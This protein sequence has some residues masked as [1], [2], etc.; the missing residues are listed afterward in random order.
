MSQGPLPGR[1]PSGGQ[2][3]G[4][5]LFLRELVAPAP[6]ALRAWLA[7]DHLDNEMIAWL[8]LQGLGPY[9]FHRLREAGVLGR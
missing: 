8:R 1:W 6:D 7:A 9:T 4:A 3:Q 5:V 2:S